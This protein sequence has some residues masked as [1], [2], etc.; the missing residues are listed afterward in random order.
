M[1]LKAEMGMKTNFHLGSP[2]K[3]AVQPISNLTNKMI[4]WVSE[5]IAVA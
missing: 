3:D 5:Y 2:E 4:F 1:N